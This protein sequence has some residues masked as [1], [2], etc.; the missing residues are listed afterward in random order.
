M[1]THKISVIT[2]T[3]DRS[4]FLER[5]LTCLSKQSFRGFQLVIVNDGGDQSVTEQLVASILSGDIEIVFI[6][7]KVSKGRA[8]A[9]NAGCNAATGEYIVFLDDDDS[10]HPDF[11]SRATQFL[12]ENPDFKALSVHAVCVEE[13]MS[14]STIIETNRYPAAFNSEAITLMGM[15]QYNRVTTNGTLFERNLY[16]ELKGFDETLSHI[17]DYDFFLRLLLLTDIAVLPEKLSYFHI[18]PARASIEAYNNTVTSGRDFH[19]QN[20]ARYRNF[21]LRND[22]QS[23]QM[24]LGHIL[25][26]A[27]Q[28]NELRH[29]RNEWHG[30]LERLSSITGLAW[31]KRTKKRLIK[32][33]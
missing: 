17:V 20:M 11:L 19:I 9:A 27:E 22:I 8:A 13:R 4:I 7:H 33:P 16:H 24:G 18:R 1:D 5:C 12:G 21:Q 32:T 14:E 6:H 23:G 3:K 15:A 10:W 2:R 25:A 26:L 29:F 28:G 30:A 31:L